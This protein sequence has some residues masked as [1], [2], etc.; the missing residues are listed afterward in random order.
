MD[1]QD[2]FLEHGRVLRD[3]FAAHGWPVTES[4]DHVDSDIRAWRHTGA[5]W[6]CT[7]HVAKEVLDRNDA[8]SLAKLLDQRSTADALRELPNGEAILCYRGPLLVLRYFE[9]PER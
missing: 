3:W 5:E 6:C 7:L 2:D 8:G 1:V 9:D 4:F